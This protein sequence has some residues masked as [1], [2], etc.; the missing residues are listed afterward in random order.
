ML[1]TMGGMNVEEIAE[2]DPDA[3]VRRHVEPGKGFGTDEARALAADAKVDDDVVDKVA[4]LLVKLY[5][6]FNAD[7]RDADRGQPAD[8]HHRPRRASRSTRR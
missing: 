6:A 7:R 3:L 1:S 2:T 5:E 8:R 4:E